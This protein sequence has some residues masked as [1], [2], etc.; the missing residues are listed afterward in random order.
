MTSGYQRAV[1]ALVRYADGP[2]RL[3]HLALELASEAGE[4]ANEIKKVY[5]DD[6]GRLSPERRARLLDELGD[7]LWGA[8]ALID[9]CGGDEGEVRQEN[10]AKLTRRMVERGRLAPAEGAAIARVM[11]EG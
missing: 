11:E 1:R 3:G 9:A 7:V 6:G 8:I 2:E 10:I 5:R 4:V